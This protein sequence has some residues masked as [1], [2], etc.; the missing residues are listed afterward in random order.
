MVYKPPDEGNL[1]HKIK[2]HSAVKCYFPFSN[3]STNGKARNKKE[4][5]SIFT[6]AIYCHLA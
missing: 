4:W 6:S 3:R 1:I 5:P 2:V